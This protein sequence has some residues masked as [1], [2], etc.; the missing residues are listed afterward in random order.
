MRLF[1]KTVTGK[2]T[3]VLLMIALP[4]ILGLLLYG[5]FGLENWREQQLA[6]AEHETALY[7]AAMDREIM[8]LEDT[9]LNLPLDNGIFD[10]LQRT[11]P[12]DTQS[13]W[14]AVVLAGRQMDSIPQIY[15][16]L[17][18]VY[19]YYPHSGL[20]LNNQINPQMT[21]AVCEA[22]A[23][24]QAGGYTWNSTETS[25]GKYLCLLVP[26]KT[27]Y[28]GVWFSCDSLL[29]YICS[30][31]NTMAAPSASQYYLT[32]PAGEALTAP[33][34]VSVGSGSGAVIAKLVR[35][36][37]L[38]LS[39]SYPVPAAQSWYGGNL[40][41]VA[42]LLAL[43]F[44]AVILGISRWVLVPIRSITE[45]IETISGGDISFRLSA[46]SGASREF[47]R[48]TE[49][50]NAM[51]DRLEDMRIRIYEQELEQQETKLRYLGQQV[52]PH[53]IL[54]SLNT[55][56]TYS[57]RDVNETRKII[58]LLSGYYRYVVNIESRYVMLEQELAHLEDFLSLQ[59]IRFPKK[60]NYEIRCEEAAKVVPIPPF[61]LENFI[62][63]A[64]KY[65]QNERGEIDIQI[66]A[67]QPEPF[68]TE[69]RISDCGAG[70][71]ED[72][73]E[74]INTFR[75]TGEKS[76]ELGVGIANCME[77]LS[78]IYQKRA[79]IR[80]LNRLDPATGEIGGATVEI[81]IHIAEE[82]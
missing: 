73:L 49:E 29:D 60:L 42:L 50:F 45:G 2:I 56:Y 26:V 47:S 18:A 33:D 31:A 25:A 65:G 44:T 74:A 72:V 61:L 28:L 34:D 23:N 57:N 80:C 64:L 82:V 36:P 5:H 54:N 12:G 40:L 15:P 43:L 20:F 7:A 27:Y 8:L 39:R 37:G 69:I 6:E 14:N 32:D 16:F 58:K 51:M 30:A 78:L 48:I 75:Q 4:A 63:N 38:Y 71:S 59:K 1:F 67:R 24:G 22:V 76:D 11:E 3:L 55:L 17:E 53:F 79:E 81:T 77:R 10:T 19:V 46:G 66:D 70:F 62:S 35:H 9:V 68:V 21:D 41:M 13:Y 52:Q